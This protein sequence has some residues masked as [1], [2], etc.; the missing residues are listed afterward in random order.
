MIDLHC[1][2]L[3]GIDD[4]S[5]DLATSLE[6]ARFAVADGITHAVCTPHVHAG[7]WENQKPAIE[8]L[9]AE[10]QHA[11]DE[12]S[13]ALR[14]APAAEVRIGA[15]IMDLLF[16]EQLPFLGERDGKR[17][18]LLELPH[19][20]IP[21]G[22]DNL[23]RWLNQQGVWPL[24]AH[25]ERNKD[26]IRD[27]ARLDAILQHDC[28]LQVTADSIAGGFGP[29]AQ[30]RAIELLEQGLV[31]LIA[32]DAHNLQHRPPRLSAGYK[33]I[34]QVFGQHKADELTVSTPWSI[35]EARF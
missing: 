3:P 18:L 12:A 5:P 27:P 16:N 15:E 13:I 32:S 8:T 35:A 34:K 17:V 11:L 14:V 33:V 6:L 25:P 4:G 9:C 29:M 7:R 2:L 31:T 22:A 30:Q 1:H 19:G 23:V 10:F 24:I 28:G 26:V 21:V 20:Q